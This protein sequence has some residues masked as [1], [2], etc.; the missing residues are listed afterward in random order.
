MLQIGF[1]MP[2]S[3]QNYKPFRNQP[4]VGL[5]L[6]SILENKFGDRVNLSIIDLRGV[7]EESLLFHIPE[8]DIFLYSVASPDFP[9]IIDIVQSLRSLYP[10]AKHIAGGPHINVFPEECSKIFDSIVLGEGEE[11][12]IN[13]VNDTL[14][15]QLKPIYRQEKS[16]DLN[17]YP[18]A[19]RKYLPRKAVVDT[20]L[21]DGESFNLP[22]TT[23][24]FSRGCPFNCYFCANKNLTYGPIRF[25]SPKLIEEEIEYLKREYQVQA[26][27]I[28][29]DNAI[30]VN[31]RVARPFLEAIG[32]TGIKWRGQSRANDI[33]PDMVRLAKEAGCTSIAMGIE[34]ASQEALKLCNKRIDLNKAKEYIKL[35]HATGI[36]VRLDF[37]IG[38]P[39]EP[40]DIVERT[41]AFIDETQP[42]SVL[43]SVLCPMPGSELFNHPERFGIKINTFDWR[44][45]A[46]VAGR[47]EEDEVPNLIFEYDEVTPWGKGMS[48]EK[49]IQNYVKLQSIFRKRGLNF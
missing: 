8:K 30:P 18:Y 24:L 15:S 10:K 13:L 20:G 27:A 36:R 11:S 41:L 5:Y 4:L 16:I 17:A 33:H 35:L 46:F 26:L 39:G 32:R 25:R 45:Y 14:T 37:I 47:F 2:S 40:D 34:S 19:S 48:K 6:L 22:A 12:V 42:Q 29:D 49:I 31:Q 7:D 9:E 38:L 1:I 21:L 23:A 3:R 28:K 44:K 43:M